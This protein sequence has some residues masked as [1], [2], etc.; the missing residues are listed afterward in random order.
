MQRKL[1]NLCFFQFDILLKCDLILRFLNFKT[2][3]SRRHPVALFL[4]IAFKGKINCCF[5]MGTV[6][7]RAPVRQIREFSTFSVSKALSHSLSARCVIA[8]NDI[9]KFLAEILFL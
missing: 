5:T 8:A 6:G 1:A 7:I 3:Y 2:L 9:C 4:I